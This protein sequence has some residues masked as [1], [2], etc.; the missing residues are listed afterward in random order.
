M[1]LFST[2]FHHHVYHCLLSLLFPR[3]LLYRA[4]LNTQGAGSFA[5][6]SATFC[7]RLN[8][9]LQTYT[10]L[11]ITS[12]ILPHLAASPAPFPSAPRHGN[13][14]VTAL[15]QQTALYLTEGLVCVGSLSWSK[16]NVEKS[17][18]E[19]GCSRGGIFCYASLV[20]SLNY[21]VMKIKQM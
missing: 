18:V 21:R 6:R 4:S 3:E 16:A 9:I 15:F 17:E 5:L 10:P 14:K 13:I 8:R 7:L 11:F 12:T 20:S 1:T 19:E 2:P